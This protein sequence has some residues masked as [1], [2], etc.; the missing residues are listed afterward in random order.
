MSL[1]QHSLCP[2]PGSHLGR[3]LLHNPEVVRVVA[4]PFY[5]LRL[6]GKSCIP[7]IHATFM[8]FFSIIISL[9][10][11]LLASRRG[12]FYFLNSDKGTNSPDLFLYFQNRQ[13]L[14]VLLSTI[15]LAADVGVS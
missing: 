8:G 14:H 9:P 3:E 7:H 10:F 1:V 11:T 5:S 6:I 15:A 13:P 4:L 2:L 12:H